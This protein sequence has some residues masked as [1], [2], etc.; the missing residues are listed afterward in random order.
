MCVH[1]RKQRSANLK[2]SWVLVP[3]KNT[4][5]SVSHMELQHN[6]CSKTF[7]KGQFTFSSL[8]QFHQGILTPN[9]T[10]TLTLHCCMDENWGSK[11]ANTSFYWKQLDSLLTSVYRQKSAHPY[12]SH[13]RTRLVKNLWG[14]A[15]V[16]LLPSQTVKEWCSTLNQIHFKSKRI[17]PLCH[18]QPSISLS[19][20]RYEFHCLYEEESQ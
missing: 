9:S 8:V 7:C 3:F 2:L 12:F 20:W 5:A 4:C 15:F 6:F 16:S 19:L 17:I 14:S 18:Q 11:D 1:L 10:C 13:T